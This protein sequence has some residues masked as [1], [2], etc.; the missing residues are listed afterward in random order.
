M[1]NPFDQFDGSP[2]AIGTNVSPPSPTDAAP[3]GGANPFDVFDGQNTAFGSPSNGTAASGTDNQASLSSVAKNFG[4]GLLAGIPKLETFVEGAL[5]PPGF[6]GKPFGRAATP[7]ETPM[8][9][10]DV[11][12]KGL[13]LIGLNPDDPSQMPQ[14]QNAPERIARMGGEGLSSGIVFPGSALTNAVI[15]TTSGVGSGIGQE[16]AP[17]GYKGLGGFLGG[18]VGGGVGAVASEVPSA[19]GAG[20]RAAADYAA[21]FTAGG[22]E[23]LAAKTLANAATD[24]DAAVQALSQPQEIVPGSMPTTFQATGDTG[25]GQLERAVATKSPDEFLA[26]RADQNAAR[27]DAL[28]NVQ[29]E[30]H[31]EAVGSFFRDQLDQ[32]DQQMQSAQDAAATSARSAAEG[33]GGSQGPDVLGEQ[34]RSAIQGSLDAAKTNEGALWKAVDPDKTMNVVASPVKQAFQNVYGNMTPEASIGLAPV[35]RQI[36]DIVSG[37]GQTL[38]LQNLVDLRSAVSGAMRDVRSPLQYNAPAYGRL[39][40]LRGA[41]EDAISQSVQQRAAEEQQAVAMGTMQPEQTT[42]ARLQQEALDFQSAKR[43]ERLGEAGGNA[44]ANVS[45]GPR[46]PSSQVGAGDEAGRSANG[47][48]GNPQAQGAFLDQD[49]ADRLKAATAATAQRKQTFGAPPVS[50]ILQRPGNSQPYTMPGGGVSSTAWKAGTGGADAVNAILKASPKAVGPLKDIAASSL[51]SKAQDGI[52]S[53][54]QFDAW[55]A[56]HAPALA[57]LEKASPGSTAAFENA[58]R[59]GDHLATIAQQRKDAIAAVEKSAVGRLLKVDDPADVVKTVGSVFNRSDAVK[60][61]RGLA[62]AAARDPAALEG[63]RRAVVEHMESKLISNTEAGTSGKN[64]IKSDAFQSFLGKNYTA[65]RQVFSDQEL[66]SMRAIAQD[67]KRANRSIT[68]KLPG[69]SNSMQ[70]YLAVGKNDL[71]QSIISKI[72]THAAGGGAGAGLASVIGATGPLGWAISG[73]GFL[74]SHVLSG[75]REAGLQSINDLV[76]EAMLNPD[77]AKSLLM[78]APKKPDTG[79]AITLANKLRSVGALSAMQ[80]S[81]Q[82]RG[83]T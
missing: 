49:T 12:K 34:T 43:A 73:L 16:V 44:G 55:K 10:G 71:H 30:G 83:G 76:K 47:A 14:P 31:P 25:L 82:Q 27:L 42:F 39:T 32:I 35:E 56:Q 79:S 61:M 18:L 53:S 74:G 24:R 60:T 59:A 75:A 57:A 63:L 17:E 81:A 48:S 66:G 40:Q 23:R 15:G 6:A 20:A 1:A 37:Y 70:D 28:S 33:L 21:P 62:Q 50:K 3:A 9:L 80:N 26:R 7:E 67:L 36:G 29:A 78:K 2:P 54:K 38:P 22:Q 64:L 72:L 8:S 45:G 68:S 69:R 58:A 52:L 41:V 13:G 5:T 19:V 4:T 65:L 51:R 77:L 11:A 46:I